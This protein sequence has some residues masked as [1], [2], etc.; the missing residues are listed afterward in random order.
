[1]IANAEGV[2]G[3]DVTWCIQLGM[4][5]AMKPVLMLDH[6]QHH[7]ELQPLGT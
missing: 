7:L 1:M 6:I 5:S 2:H 3:P 4:T